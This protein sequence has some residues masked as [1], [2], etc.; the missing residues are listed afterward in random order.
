MPSMAFHISPAWWPVLLG[1]LLVLVQLRFVR[2]RRYRENQEWAE[3]FNQDC[4]EPQR[5]GVI[6]GK[7]LLAW[8][9]VALGVTW[10][11]PAPA[12][13]QAVTNKPDSG[14][15]QALPPI[16]CPL[17][18]AGID[19]TK[20]KPFEEVEKYIQFLERA[21]RGAVGRNPMRW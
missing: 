2:T 19:P 16:E 18:K 3:A 9:M 6:M 13:A 20:L 4:A 5:K 17:R 21:D 11:G 7:L 14:A 12:A 8:M 1:A 10:M 15:K